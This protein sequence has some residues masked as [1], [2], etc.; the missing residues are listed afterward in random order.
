MKLLPV[1]LI[2]SLFFLLASTVLT[3][4]LMAAD[5][6]ELNSEKI[7]S[8]MEKQLDL[9]REKW[10]QLKP[11]IEE[12]SKEMAEGIKESVEK[13]YAGLDQLTQK[14][15]SMSKET[16]QKVKDVLSSEEAMRLRQELAK[17]DKE[18]IDQAKVKM[19]AKLNELL[20]LT[21]EQAQKLKPVLEDSINQVAEKMQ[22][23]AQ[24]GAQDWNEFKKNLEK[25]TRDLYDKVQETLDDEQ[26]E[27]LEKYNED[28]KEDI[29]KALFTV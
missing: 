16:E 9:S 5:I 10:E 11:V 24:E 23:V 7:I 19:I 15:D 25:L 4:D 6:E 18:A 21:E 17:I 13:G 12:K 26:M 1:S 22:E 20:A 8:E 3:T 2:L 14:F 29:K 28:Q 27:K